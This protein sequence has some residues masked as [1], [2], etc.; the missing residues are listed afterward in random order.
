MLLDREVPTGY[1]RLWNEHYSQPLRQEASESDSVVIFRVGTELFALQTRLCVEVASMRPIRSL[2]HRR[3]GA[4][5]G[6]ASVRG[7]LLVCLSLAA[8]LNTTA[9]VA[10]APAA[11]AASRRLLVTDWPEGRVA[12]PV[13][14]VQS[15]HRFGAQEL[16]PAP[17]TV[18]QSATS[19]SRGLLSYGKRTV[20]VLDADRLR[21]TINRCFA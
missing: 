16:A 18:A 14:E 21:R 5:L 19:Y 12:F 2:P 15:V 4:L 8:I 3:H 1:A 11:E 7:E 9:A 17:A 13:D 20:G 6:L 10:A